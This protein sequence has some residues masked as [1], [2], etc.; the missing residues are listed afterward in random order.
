MPI[1]TADTD[2]LTFTAA[3]QQWI[4][5]A[6]VLVAATAPDTGAIDIDR[7]G[8]SL[9]NHGDIS[10]TGGGQSPPAAIS[11]RSFIEG[12]YI[13]NGEGASI[14]GAT[15]V[16]TLGAGTSVFNEGTILGLSGTG[17]LF[18]TFFEPPDPQEFRDDLR[19][20]RRRR[21]QSQ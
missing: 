7:N 3:N 10:A 6:G 18:D 13:F 11:V 14:L 12:T 16:A 2:K 5:K 19:R 21:G 20:R 8:A 9:F 17:V 1:Q 15:G 4:V